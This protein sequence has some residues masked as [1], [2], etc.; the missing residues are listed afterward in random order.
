MPPLTGAAQ[1][2]VFIAA[3]IVCGEPKLVDEPSRRPEMTPAAGAAQ[4][5]EAEDPHRSNV[6][7]GDKPHCH[8]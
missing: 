8:L 5:W 2:L 4:D 3:G 6:K 1:R 7:R